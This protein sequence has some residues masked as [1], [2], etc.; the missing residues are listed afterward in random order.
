MGG[1]HLVSVAKITPSSLNKALDYRLPDCLFI[2]KT[3]RYTVHRGSVSNK[4]DDPMQLGS[5]FAE[6][7]FTGL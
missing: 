6:L 2:L 4:I 7:K 5:I 3:T 1:L